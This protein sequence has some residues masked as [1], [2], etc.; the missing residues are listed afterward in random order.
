LSNKK[1]VKQKGMIFMATKPIT[2][3]GLASTT[4]KQKLASTANNGNVTY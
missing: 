3:T 2:L 1:E 4:I